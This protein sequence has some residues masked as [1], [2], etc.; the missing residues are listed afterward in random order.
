MMFATVAQFEV[1]L[2]GPLHA[3]EQDRAAALLEDVSAVVADLVDGDTVDGWVADG[4]PPA[5]VAVVC[6]AAHRAL[7][8]PLQHASVTEGS[9]TWRADNVSGVWLTDDERSTVRRAAGIAGWSSVEKSTE[10][11]FDGAV[12]TWV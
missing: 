10:Y 2:P 9:Y 7:V 6:S 3:D 8:N 1:R 5:V 4:A 11:G 12:W